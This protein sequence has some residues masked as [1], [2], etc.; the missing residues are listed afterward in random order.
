VKPGLLVIEPHADDG[1]ISIGGFLEKNRHLYDYAFFLVLASDLHMH[2]QGTVSRE[3]RV[4][5]F[6]TYVEYFDGTMVQVTVDEDSYPIDFDS[7]LD[8]YPKRKLVRAIEK[9]IE[10]VQPQVLMVTGPS[11]HHDHTL[12]YEATIAALRPT[13]R[14]LPKE[15]YFL[16]NP[17]YVHSGNPMGRFVPDTFIELSE[18]LLRTKTELLH[19]LFPS[20]IR[21]DTN[22][23]SPNGIIDWARYRGLEARCEFA[24]ALQTFY[25]RL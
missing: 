18:D 4:N 21:S 11:F 12:V 14:Y 9:A 8:T 15:V 1:L 24:E 17:T 23:L 20:Q 22:Y 6:Q 3:T 19:Q 13:S 2:H 16:E 7:Q 10:I 25:R 5:E